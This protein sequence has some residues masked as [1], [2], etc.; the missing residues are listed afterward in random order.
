MHMYFHHFFG[1][2]DSCIMV[3]VCVVLVMMVM[4]VMVM[5]ANQ[6]RLLRLSNWCA[7]L[8]VQVGQQEM[9]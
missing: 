8:Q 3:N 6:V 2:L 4:L 9:E 7:C 5:L 1:R